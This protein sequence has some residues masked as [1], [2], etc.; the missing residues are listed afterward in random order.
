MSRAASRKGVE[1]GYRLLDSGDGRRLEQ[2]GPYRLAR[3]AAE[4][5]WRPG[6]EASEWN[7]VSG[8]FVRRSGGDGSWERQGA[9]PDSIEVE[10]AGVNLLAR[11]T[12]FGHIGLFPEQEASWLWAAERIRSSGRPAAVLCLF[13][14]TGA[15]T[16]VCAKAGARVCHVDASKGTVDWARRNA[17][18][19]GLADRPIRWIVEDVGKF[20]AREERRGS[21]YDGIILDPPTYGRGTRGETW[22]IQDDL[23][24]LLAA[25]RKILSEDPLFVL[26]HAYTPWLPM[27]SVRNVMEDALG[28]LPGTIE[29][30]ELF[31]A[32]AGRGRRLPRGMFV[33]F[34]GKQPR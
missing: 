13:A 19:S 29:H 22:K 15:S 20:L 1:N 16:L 2:V 25:C 26:L 11:L 7:A 10:V 14:Y 3:P 6:R 4:A 23:P 18:A 27:L 9:M 5:I 31:V 32:E 12:A 34:V 33:R 30:G 24:G 28:D 17:E 21:R 8:E